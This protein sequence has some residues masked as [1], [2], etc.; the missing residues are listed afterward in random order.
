[1]LVNNTYWNDEYDGKSPSNNGLNKPIKNYKNLI[2]NREPGGWRGE[3]EFLN[4]AT[5][6]YGDIWE[7]KARRLFWKIFVWR[8]ERWWD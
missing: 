3:F 5:K 4:T 8:Y 2:D 1:M 7:Y 6:W